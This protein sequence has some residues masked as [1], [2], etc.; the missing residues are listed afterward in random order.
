[1]GGG[2]VK[3]SRQDRQRGQ[4]QFQALPSAPQN[5]DAPLDRTRRLREL[6]G[7]A[8][9]ELLRTNEIARD[10]RFP[11]PEAVRQY[12]RRHEVPYLTRGRIVLVDRRDFEKSMS[13]ARKLRL[14]KSA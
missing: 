13:T 4:E 6:F 8:P 3:S 7:I 12:L 9:G 11:S 14:S 5:L 2:L 1:M 10:Y